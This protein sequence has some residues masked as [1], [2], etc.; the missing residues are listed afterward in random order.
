MDAPLLLPDEPL[1]PTPAAWRA[2]IAERRTKQARLL[3]DRVREAIATQDTPIRV[4]TSLIPLSVVH[5]VDLVLI[6]LGWKTR[7][8]RAEKDVL[9]L[10]QR[11][12][13]E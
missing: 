3:R 1:I 12:D 4:D 9:M 10:S 11:T 2:N 7:W 13:S 8:S 5:E 6:D